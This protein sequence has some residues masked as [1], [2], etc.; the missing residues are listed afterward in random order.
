M[1]DQAGEPQHRAA[2]DKMAVHHSSHP[3]HD[4][5]IGGEA[6]HILNAV[7]EIPRGSK[8]KYELD[9]DTGK[10]PVGGECNLYELYTSSACVPTR[11]YDGP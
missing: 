8:V 10:V 4:L 7:I 5:Y 2:L 9:K 6:P 11:Y 1:E 3:W